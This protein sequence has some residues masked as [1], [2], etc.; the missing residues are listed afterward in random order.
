MVFKDGARAI[1]LQ[2]ADKI[3]D[4]IITGA[5]KPRERIPSVREYAA[6]M[7]VNANTM[8]R[9]YDY[10]SGEGVIFNR[11]GVGFF[12]EDG[13][14]ERIRE[15]RQKAFFGGEIQE[16]FHRINLLGITPEQ[17][18]ELYSQYLAEE[19]NMAQ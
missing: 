4:D 6:A 5:V 11:R 2:I 14:C 17:L 1:Y 8:M 3:C 18:T 15:M 9:T 12:V 16:I 10:L 7:Q 13:A 19:A